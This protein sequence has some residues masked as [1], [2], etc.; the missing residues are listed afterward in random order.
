MIYCSGITL[1]GPPS[2]PSRFHCDAFVTNFTAAKFRTFYCSAN[3]S[4]PPSRLCTCFVRIQKIALGDEPLNLTS[5]ARAEK[6]CAD[7]S[8]HRRSL[9]ARPRLSLRTIWARV[10]SAL[11]SQHNR[12]RLAG[13]SADTEI[14]HR[15][16]HKI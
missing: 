2:S 12:P 1:P 14:S 5:R 16:S 13:R 7:A 11:T 10:E 4:S 3:S 6:N 15:T 8:T 9:Y